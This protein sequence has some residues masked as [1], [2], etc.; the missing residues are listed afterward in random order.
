M[1][2]TLWVVRGQLSGWQAASHLLPAAT[3]PPPPPCTLLPQVALL[4]G[5]PVYRVARVRLITPPGAAFDKGE[6]R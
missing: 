4:R 3:A 1:R 6:K 5:R 2:C